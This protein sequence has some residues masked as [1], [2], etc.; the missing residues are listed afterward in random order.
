[1]FK[2]YLKQE[3]NNV[4]HSA[5]PV[6]SAEPSAEPTEE[7]KPT[8]TPAPVTVWENTTGAIR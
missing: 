5:K 7:P 4:V 8:T 6:A 2:E 1:M 3:K